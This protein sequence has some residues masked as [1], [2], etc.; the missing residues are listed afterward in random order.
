MT[1]TILLTRHGQ[2]E[3]NRE[4]RF[5][6]R[7]DLPLNSTGER[8]A[9]ALAERLAAFPVSA[10]YSGPLQRAQRTAEICSHRLGLPYQVLPGL[11]DVDYG[12]WQGL[13][14]AEVAD[15]YPEQYR[16]WRDAPA[17]VRF[18]GGE[19]FAEMQARAVAALEDVIS[20]HSGQ[21][22]VLV[23]HMGVNK[24]LLC[25]VLGL[26]LSHYW[27]LR[28]D[29]CCLNIFRCLAPQ[30]YEIVTLNDTCHMD[31]VG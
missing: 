3:W 20:R 30:R 12:Q 4:E 19:S 18:P 8:Q 1:T 10:I 13:S 11:L 16:Q 7:M 29:T 9:E 14:P 6:G 2:T 5:R 27:A 26:D 15:R 21:T 28:Q 31:G 25:A 23:A 22:V 24:A 17:Q